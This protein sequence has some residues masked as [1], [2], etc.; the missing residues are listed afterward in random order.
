VIKFLEKNEEADRLILLNAVQALQKKEIAVAREKLL[1]L[2]N[3]PSSLIK[4]EALLNLARLEMLSGNIETA[5]EIYKTVSLDNKNKAEVL[6]EAS[7]ADLK[8]GNH[9]ASLGK[10]IGLQSSYFSYAFLPNVFFIDAY[11]R[12]ALCDFGGAEQ[13]I[14]TFF[15]EYQKEFLALKNIKQKNLY[16]TIIHFVSEKTPFRFQRYLLHLPT[17]I[18]SQAALNGIGKEQK[19]IEEFLHNKYS[20]TPKSPHWENFLISLKKFQSTQELIWINEFEKNAEKEIFFL[21]KNLEKQLQDAKLLL[22]DISSQATTD[23]TLQSA[24]NYP[25]TKKSEEEKISSMQKVRWSFEQEIWE[26]ELEFLKVKNPSK[27]AKQHL[28][29]EI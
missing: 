13:T 19:K 24:L 4:N 23:N 16:K 15:N 29:R 1:L 10:A 26:D 2:L 28:A 3:S 9:S 7:Y 5:A 8:S 6:L 21:T 11:N 17:I 18:N 25:A 20:I 22:L 14:N 27:C 12:K